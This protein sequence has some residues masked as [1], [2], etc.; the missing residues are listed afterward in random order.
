M[1]LI[2]S[3]SWR[4][5]KSSDL[6]LSCL[7]QERTR[8]NEN[9]S[10]YVSEIKMKLLPKSCSS[11]YV[12]NLAAKNWEREC[13][14]NQT[15]AKIQRKPEKECVRRSESEGSEHESSS[16]LSRPLFK[17]SGWVHPRRSQAQRS[18][19]RWRRWDPGAIG[20]GSGDP[21][22]G[23]LVPPPLARWFLNGYKLWKYGVRP[24]VCSKRCPN[25]FSKEF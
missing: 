14:C 7:Q 10:G 4:L 1:S 25:Y 19:S 9:N 2:L 20:S 6:H 23:P 12:I 13:S 11:N 16:P 18:G 3:S 21:K 5:R 22:V 24:K 8:T 17:E 15:W